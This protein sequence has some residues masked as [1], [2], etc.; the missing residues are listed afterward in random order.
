[1]WFIVRND[2]RK[3]VLTRDL[4]K[5]NSSNIGADLNSVFVTKMFNFN[6]TYLSY[7]LKTRISI[8]HNLNF[9]IA[10]N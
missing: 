7:L 3:H 6:H 4:R 1:M 2:M 9:K 10:S 5:K 8:Q